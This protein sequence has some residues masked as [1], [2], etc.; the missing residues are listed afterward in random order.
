MNQHT[1]GPWKIARQGISPGWLI[2]S[3]FE[4]ELFGAT[5]YIAQNLT[6]EADARLIAAAPELLAA[7]KEA[8][9]II[10]D[11]H[12]MLTAERLGRHG[13]GCRGGCPDAATAHRARA[14][15]AK[16]EGR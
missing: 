13:P 7:L 14:L 8:V 3:D 6:H 11:A 15:L 10:E 5:H 2:Y 16:I 4:R 9:D 1:P 12:A